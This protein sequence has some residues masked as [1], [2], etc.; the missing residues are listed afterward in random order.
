MP[1]DN[2]MGR[3][4]DKELQRLYYSPN[5][6][7]AFGGVERLR[8]ATNNKYSYQDIADWLR[9]QDVYTLHKPMRLHFTRRRTLVSQ[10]DDVWQMDLVDM[11]EYQ[12]DNDGCKYLLTCIDVFS[13]YAWVVPVKNKT[14]PTIL[15]AIK[16]ILKGG[17]KPVKIQTDYGGEFINKHNKEYLKEIGIGLY[18]TNSETK[19]AVVERFNRT[20]KSRMWR[21][22]THR[23]NYR[24]M[25]IIG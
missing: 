16:L 20:L 10:I 13:K 6:K 21:Y 19:A 17:R 9:T 4:L 22:F 14:G 1:L 24:Y 3:K 5:S 23:G 12:K 8:R 7:G 2:D 18:T 25:D 11:Q 15:D